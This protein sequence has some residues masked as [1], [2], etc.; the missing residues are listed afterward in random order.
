VK[1]EDITYFTDD[2]DVYREVLPEQQHIIGKSGTTA[3]ERDNSN[4]RHYLA[5][6]TRRTKVVSKS[7][8]MVDLSLRLMYYFTQPENYPLWQQ[9]FISVFS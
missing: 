4:T 3:I 7:V 9:R 2:W 1:G 6:M 8:E 5:R